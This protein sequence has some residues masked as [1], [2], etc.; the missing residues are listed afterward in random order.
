MRKIL[1]AV[2]V[3]LSGSVLILSSGITP[4]K[5][6]VVLLLFI[7]LCAGV[8]C[9]DKRI[10]VLILLAYMAAAAAVPE[11]IYGLPVIGYHMCDCICQVLENKKRYDLIFALVTGS[12]LCVCTA[13]F[14]IQTENIRSMPLRITL[15]VL[16]TAAASALKLYDYK[17][18]KL[19]E[20]F[21]RTKD[22]DREY[23]MALKAKN[24]YLIEKQ[25]AQIYSATLKERN[26]IAR[27]IHDNVGHLLSRS[28]LQMGAVLAV[29]KDE[30]LKPMLLGV[31]DTLNSA[32]SSIRSS[33]H[34][35][36]DESVD[37]KQNIEEILS[38]MQDYA[39][40]F[41]Y[42]VQD[43]LPR[44]LKYC[45]IAI[46]KE[47]SSNIIKHSNADMV[48]IVLREH[49]AFYQLMIHDNGKSAAKSD[50]MGIGLENMQQRVE[51]FAGRLEI[52]REAGFKIFIHIPKKTADYK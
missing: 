2:I 38:E 43:E 51:A 48:D 14:F 35:L 8:Y 22:N 25:D 10:T 50:G 33:V 24:Q 9:K 6:S 26:R 4:V 44:E 41:E 20:E 47:A 3:Y 31:K 28:L 45:M 34:D 37:L 5:L 49:P 40:H 39:V 18:D 23:S 32:M 11:G 16:F 17:Y 12:I 42:D 19:Y 46:V 7:V 15:C 29:N 52:N 13:I 30:N 1:T 36:H 27:E 21:V